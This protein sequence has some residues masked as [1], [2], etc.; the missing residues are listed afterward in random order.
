MY[1]GKLLQELTKTSPES[2]PLGANLDIKKDA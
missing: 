2:V 1:R